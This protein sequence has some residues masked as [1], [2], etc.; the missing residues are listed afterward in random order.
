MLTH[1]HSSPTAIIIVITITATFT[2]AF[3]TP[4]LTYTDIDP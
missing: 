1:F 3:L 2:V 4:V